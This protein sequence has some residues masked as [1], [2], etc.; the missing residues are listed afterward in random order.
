LIQEFPWEDWTDEFE[1]ALG[2]GLNCIEWTV[3]LNK[4]E[5]NPIFDPN[6][7]NLIHQLTQSSGIS[8]ESV[9]LDNF[10]E[11]PLHKI[12]AKNNLKSDLKK[13]E[14]IVDRVKPHSINTLVL[15]IVR[16]NG[17][18]SEETLDDLCR[19]LANIQPVLDVNN[20]FLAL[21]LELSNNLISRVV[22][23]LAGFKNIGFNFDIG[24]SA[25]LGNDPIREIQLYGEKLFNIHIKDRTYNGSTVPL[26]SGVA[27][28][29]LIFQELNR[30][31]YGRNY[32]LQ[33]ARIPNQPE[34][35][36]IKNYLDFCKNAGL[37]ISH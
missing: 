13:L 15:P 27:R 19:I 16:E 30:N 36:T 33:A 26:G 11:A 23:S 2:C 5:I 14:W 18:E 4:F 6:Y 20:M 31:N 1:L 22:E 37:W 32:I 17:E 7:E 21:E 12:N 28:F 29:K 8:V 24:N 10:V 35:V 34:F 9:T 25:S 3:D